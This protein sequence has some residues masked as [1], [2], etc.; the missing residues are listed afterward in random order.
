MPTL[1]D[2]TRFAGVRRHDVPRGGSL[3]RTRYFA[4]ALLVLML[5]GCGKA[6]PRRAPVVGTIQ[7]QGQPVV[8]A[9]VNFVPLDRRM[10]AASATTDDA[11][12]Y[13]LQTIGMGPGAILGTHQVSVIL[14]GPAPPAPS[15]G[16][17]LRDLQQRPLGKPLIPLRYFTPEESGL[18]AEV[19][20]VAENRCDFRLEP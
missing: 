19:A 7:F 20:D 8:A 17:A 10:R 2:E 6:G 18:T 13:R 3:P 4:G 5:A 12:T 9:T 11:G 1:I 16:N 15:T 14:R